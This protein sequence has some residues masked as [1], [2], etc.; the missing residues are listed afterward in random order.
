MMAE[1]PCSERERIEGL[2]AQQLASRL[3]ERD[4]GPAL[5]AIGA[6]V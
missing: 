4:V 1:E 2:D 5:K 6:L 3:L